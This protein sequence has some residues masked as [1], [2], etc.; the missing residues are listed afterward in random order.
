M[1]KVKVILSKDAEI[2]LRY[3]NEESNKSKIEKS[4][5]KSVLQKF[6]LLKLNFQYGNPIAKKL[7]PEKY[8]KN[9]E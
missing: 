8:I 2:V 3:L 4:I 9:T 1:K 7:I 6:E 5:L